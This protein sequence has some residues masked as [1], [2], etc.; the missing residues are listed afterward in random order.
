M[1]RAGAGHAEGAAKPAARLSNDEREE[2]LATAFDA[3]GHHH[4]VSSSGDRI[5]L[6]CGA[7]ARA[8]VFPRLG[9]GWRF[10]VL[11]TFAP[12]AVG[13]REAARAAGRL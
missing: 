1:L 13:R 6:A 2:L 3:D 5:Q 4:V 10:V 9:V 12:E 8:S 7:T 11:P